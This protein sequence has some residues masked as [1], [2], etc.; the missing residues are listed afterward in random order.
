MSKWTLQGKKALITGSTKGIG[1]AAAQEM[2]ELGAEVFINSRHAGEVE[3]TVEELT[4]A[5]HVAY[6]FAADLS[7]HEGREQLLRSVQQRWSH[8]DILVNNVG[9]NI[10]KSFAD[11]EE[12]EYRQIFETNLMSALALT[13]ACYPML[14]AAGRASVVNVASVAALVDVRSGAPY[15]MTKAAMVQMT[16]SLAVEWAPEGIRVNA[17]SP[18]YTRTPLAAPVLEQ[19][20]RLQLILNRTPM[21]R[22]A[23]AEEM[24]GIIA[25][26]A[27]EQSSYVTGQNIVADGGMTCAGL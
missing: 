6:G 24:A 10:R 14:K 9:M 1:L 19:P 18:W 27:M 21:G 17:V 12:T 25:F 8:L 26:L 22:I 13:Q 11:Y 3:K 4:R 2:A 20:E 16:R 5:G 7:T 23:E 15:G